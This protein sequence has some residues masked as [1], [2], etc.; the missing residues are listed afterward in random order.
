MIAEIIPTA[1]D[2][3][4]RKVPSSVFHRKAPWALPMGRYVSQP[5]TVKCESIRDVRRFLAGCRRMSKQDL[6]G[7]YWQP[8]E[9]FEQFKEGHCV[10]F[11]LWTW[12]QLL[13]LGYEARFVGGSCGGY[14][15]GHAWVEYFKDGK[16][17]LVEP[18]Y[19]IVG[20]TIPR[21][22]TMSYDPMV[23]VAWDGKTLKYF[24]HQ[25][26][27]SSLIWWMLPPLVWEWLAIWASYWRRVG[28]PLWARYLW[29]RW[30]PGANP[31]A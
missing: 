22:T 23:S 24:V 11:S 16:Y 9:E 5:L 13:S 29:R 1:Y 6:E 18:Q 25:H 8:P 31:P 7:Y 12:R 19:S 20:D 3:E 15:D 2:A 27:D 30:Q 17:F 4:G 21:L 28:L 26:R 10:D 14:G